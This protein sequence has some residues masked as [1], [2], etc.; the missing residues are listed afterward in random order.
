VEA[1]PFAHRQ[2]LRYGETDMPQVVSYANDLLYAEVGRIAYL[3]RLGIEHRR[4]LLARGVDCTIGEAHV[5]Y[6]AA[7]RFDDEFDIKVRV[8]EIRPA[9]WSFEY[10]IRS[11]R[12]R[13]LRG[14]RTV[15]VVVGGQAM[16]A[17]RLPG[18]LRMG[19][20]TAKAT[21]PLREKKRA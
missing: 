9:S 15:Q 18:D 12:R 10:A 14:A 1:Y 8:G 3:R 2:R 5:R 20:A 4:E 11:R 16:R 21:Q 19:L 6:R 7:R 13:A 17:Q